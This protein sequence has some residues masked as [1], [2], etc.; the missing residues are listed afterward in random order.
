MVFHGIK[1]VG[2]EG[3]AHGM[4]SVI[5]VFLK[6]AGGKSD[7]SRSLSSFSENGLN[8]T[9]LL[10]SQSRRRLLLSVRKASWQVKS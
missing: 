1:V 10:S 2:F 3:K 5:S 8:L 9:W 4:Y 6:G 7:C